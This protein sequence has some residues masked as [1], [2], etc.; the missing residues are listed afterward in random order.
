MGLPGSGKTTL[1]R[2]LSYHFLLPHFNADTLREK[3]KDWDF[4]EEGRIR[5]AYRMASYDYGIFDFVCPLEKM[6]F[7]FQADFTIWMDTIQE[8]RFEDTNN[9]FEKPEHYDIRIEKW[10][11]LNRLHNSLEGFNPGIQDIQNFLKEQLPKLA[12]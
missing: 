3:H 7:I 1:A 4:S 8:G 9:V 5:Q 11:G 6:R 10:I 12:K 2:E